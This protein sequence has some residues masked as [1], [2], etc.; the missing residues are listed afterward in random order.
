MDNYTNDELLR[1]R[2]DFIDF[3]RKRNY[4]ESTLGVIK[5][6]INNLFEFLEKNSYSL[7]R[8]G[9]D[10]YLEYIFNS[11]LVELTKNTIFYITR[12]FSEYFFD[13]TY[14][15]NHPYN[16][17]V[18][19][20]LNNYYQGVLNEYMADCKENGNKDWTITNKY[21]R[22]SRFL[23]ECQSRN[24]EN[25]N[26]LDGYVLL[27]IL[28]CFNSD[29]ENI[30]PSIALFLN[31]L[32]K[33]DLVQND[34]SL[35][36]P[37]ITRSEKLPTVYTVDEIKKIE[38]SIDT[39]TFKGK[40]DKAALLLATRLGIRTCDILN[41]K[42]DNLNFKNNTINFIQIKT[43]TEITLPMVDDVK[44]ALEDY[45]EER[46][47]ISVP[48]ENIFI[49]VKGQNLKPLHGSALRFALTSYFDKAGVDYKDKKHGLHSLRSSLASSMVNDNV[50]YDIVRKVLGHTDD[51]SIKHYAR[52]DIEE[53][54]KCA[55][56]VPAPSGKFKM[57]LED[58]SL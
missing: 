32:A 35:L 30:W 27:S 2:D 52:I 9:V 1:I 17:F 25:L 58:G 8:D 56:E 33:K 39:S 28:N 53:L 6:R 47:K 19:P 16:T 29:K 51:D 11:E 18:Q 54:R 41:L 12:R 50:S 49:A 22:I 40:R 38:D 23:F 45:L 48:I 24:I 42:E 21:R 15:P 46:N 5:R 43:D 37:K 20:P 3:L 4:Q 44:K 34:L 55:I 13:G 7:T 26:D 14:T 57:F 31:Y 36:I 10:K